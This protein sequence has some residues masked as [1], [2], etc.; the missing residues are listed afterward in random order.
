MR[1]MKDSGI[2]WIEEIPENWNVFNIRHLFSFGKGLPITKENL[3]EKG[4]SV[5]SYGQIHSKLNKGTSIIPELIRYVDDSYLTSN[6]ESLTKKGDFIFADTSEDVLGCGNCV[7]VDKDITLFAGYHTI[8]LRNKAKESSK[9]L[10]YLFSTDAWRKQIRE[11][12]AGVKL[13]SVSQKILRETSIILPPF[14][15]QERIVDCLDTECARIDAVMEQTRASIEEYKKLK[16]SIITEAVTKGIRKD[17]PMKDSGIDWIGKIP[18]DWTVSSIGQKIVFEGGGQPPLTEFIH[19]PREGYVRLIQNRDYKT[20]AYLTYVPANSVSKFCNCDDVMIGRYGPP[21]FVLHRGL[22]GAYN[23]ALMK[24]IPQEIDRE[25]MSFVLQE[26]TMLK[27]I[28]S[29]S[30]R[31]AGQDGV[32][33]VILK[34]YPLPLPSIEEQKEI[35]DYL[36]TTCASIDGIIAQKER[37]VS[38]ME[39]YKK[40][41][42]FEYVTGKKEI[43]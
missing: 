5:I 18:S 7:Y 11:R 1:A 23:V 31:A 25:W 41:L 13:F 27:Y 35:A 42:I 22:E 32:N 14:V 36:N 29:F 15:E 4:V 21:T 2:P 19:E 39:S 28:E 8:I 34:K 3:K 40:S 16:Q 33:P 38:E 43:V 37:F 24:A 30:K 10:A 9:Y 12:V 6:P 26:Y 20:D 17:R